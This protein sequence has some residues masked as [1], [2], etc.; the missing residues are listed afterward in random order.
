MK[1]AVLS[2]IH[3]N[4][5]AF[6]LVLNSLKKENVDKIVLLGDYITDGEKGNE[7]LNIIKKLKTKY[8]LLGNRE[9]YIL[10][11]SPERK[12]YNNYKTIANTYHSLTKENM[13]YLKDMKE[14]FLLEVNNIKI[15]MLHGDKY[16]NKTDNLNS[17]FD[18]IISEFDFDICLFGHTHQYLNKKYKGKVFLNPGSVG[19]PTDTPTYKYCIM[20]INDDINIDVKEFNV[21][22]TFHRLE[23]EYKNSIYYKENYVWSKLLLYTIR[24]SND[25]CV[26]FLHFLSAKKIKALEQL[27]ADKF[28]QIWNNT[29][30]EFCKQF[31]LKE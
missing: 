9:K 4:L 23:E 26:A 21:K 12:N 29:Y 13:K 11:Y 5:I 25:Y 8:V 16:I 7:V 3:S 19:Q 6:E 1:I 14:Y 10:N 15:L 30:Q 22:D 24:D 18:L 20:T 27:E 17:A 28:N 2:D 31:N